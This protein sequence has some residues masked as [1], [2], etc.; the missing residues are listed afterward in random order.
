MRY[1]SI[2]LF[3]F[4]LHISMA[5]LNASQLTIVTKQTSSDWFDQ[6]EAMLDNT[7][8]YTEVSS[9]YDFGFGDFI[10]GMWYFVQTFG[11][12][13][14]WVPR[15]LQMFGIISPFSYYFS[16]PVYIIYVLGIA[17]FISNRNTKGMR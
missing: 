14:I 10:K 5:L 9:T 16:L 4:F 1:V 12:G 15:T 7:Y 3:V 11:F 17:Q 6:T 2:A 13:I 8:D